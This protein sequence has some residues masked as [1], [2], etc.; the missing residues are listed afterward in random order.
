M[1]SLCSGGRVR[2]LPSAG[3][4]SLAISATRASIASGGAPH[5]RLSDG[6]TV[7]VV[8]ARDAD[9]PA[10]GESPDLSPELGVHHGGQG[11]RIFKARVLS[12]LPAH[13]TKRY[14]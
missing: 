11:L 4:T 5:R 6:L 9:R 2:W 14:L 3:E 12:R 8:V 10:S 7:D 1:R 13:H